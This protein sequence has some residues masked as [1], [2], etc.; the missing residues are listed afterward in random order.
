MAFEEPIVNNR[1]QGC[2]RVRRLEDKDISCNVHV[3]VVVPEDTCR[4]VGS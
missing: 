2:R 3:A 1:R 4:D